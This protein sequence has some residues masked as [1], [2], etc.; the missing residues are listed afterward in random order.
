MP[1]LIS[2]EIDK[3]GK[4]VSALSYR[5]CSLT[6]RGRYYFFAFAPIDF[7]YFTVQFVIW[8]GSGTPFVLLLNY[9]GTPVKTWLLEGVAG[10]YP[11]LQK[12]GCI[13]VCGY[14]F[15]VGNKTECRY[16]RRSPV[17]KITRWLKADDD[18]EGGTSHTNLCVSERSLGRHSPIVKHYS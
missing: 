11:H 6:L 5:V 18:E 4:S 17:H 1:K 2:S 10:G 3:V 9:V 8:P 13:S 7:N 15:L 16:K 14:G 12:I